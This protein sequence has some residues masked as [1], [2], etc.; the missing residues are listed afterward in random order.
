MATQA[1]VELSNPVVSG[2]TLTMDAE[3]Q[4]SWGNGKFQTSVS[5]TSANFAAN[6]R[7]LGAA[8]AAAQVPV[9][10]APTTF[11]IGAPT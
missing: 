8:W 1:I 6:A 5:G 2:T 7:A 10:Q 4:G 11:L 9:Q 3:V